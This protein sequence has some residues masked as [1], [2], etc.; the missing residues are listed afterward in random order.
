M[1][2][3]T[4]A[5]P[6]SQALASLLAVTVALTATPVMATPSPA[7]LVAPE[8]ITPS[9]AS[10]ARKPVQDRAKGLID[11]GN[12]EQAAELL[13]EEAAKLHDPL[14]FLDSAEAYRLAG[15]A[16]RS[17]PSLETGTEKARVGLDILHFLQDA[18]C[19]PSWQVVDRAR[20]TAEISRG[21]EILAAIEQTTRDLDKKVEA[22]PPVEEEKKPRKKAPR[23]GRGFIAVGSVLSVVGVAGLGI[24]GA[25]LAGANGAQKDIDDLAESLKNGT[26]DQVAF[27]A[28]KADIDA[29]GQR[30]NTLTYAGIGVGVVGLAAGIALLVVGVK[31]RKRYR[32][33]YG[34]GTGDDTARAIIVPVFGPERAGLAFTARF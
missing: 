17:K 23:D 7:W 10:S 22:P 16:E 24:M 1:F 34:S 2:V 25:G 8:A 3:S 19:D 32:A 9:Q 4:S 6:R 11:A 27:D 21:E 26:I 15:A 18:R 30:G 5:R 13:A 29:K 12:P 31:K 33:E 14:L 28:Q 20:V